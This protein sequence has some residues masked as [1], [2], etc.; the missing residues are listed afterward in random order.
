[1]NFKIFPGSSSKA[2]ADRKKRGEDENTQISISRQRKEL[3]R[4]N[5][6]HFIY[7]VFE[8]LLFGEKL[9]FDKK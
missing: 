2:M 6:K 5:K 8:G 7:M 1:M 3:F 4:W 9:T